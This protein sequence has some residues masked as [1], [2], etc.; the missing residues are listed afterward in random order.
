MDNWWRGS[1]SELRFVLGVSLLVQGAIAAPR[2]TG[3]LSCAPCHRRIFEAYSRTPMA[4][5]SGAPAG[6]AAGRS[7]VRAGYRYRISRDGAGLWLDLDKDSVKARKRL[8]HFV[9]SGAMA[10]AYLLEADGFLFEAPVA[11]YAA[12]RKWDLAPGYGLYTYPFLARSIQPGC[13][14]CHATG[15]EPVPGTQSRFRSP[16]FHE[17]GIGCERC[18]GPGSEHVASRG[19]IVNP[20]K[21][22]ADRRDSICAQCHLQ[23]EVRVMRPGKDWSSYQPGERL[24]DTMTIFVRGGADLKVTSHGERLAQSACKQAGGERMWCG[25]CHDPHALPKPAERAAWFRS[26]CLACHETGACRERLAARR[27]AGDDCTACHMPKNPVVD[28]QH[29]VYT[30]HSIP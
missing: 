14:S 5:S 24:A 7:F 30:D 23:G 21:L 20:A 13:L 11:Y 3:S 17:A 8:S 6:D 15:V 29:V 16:P 12:S 18:H 19:S 27:N 2:N 22:A 9:G 28:A 1:P 4:Q 26:K 25:S 10:R